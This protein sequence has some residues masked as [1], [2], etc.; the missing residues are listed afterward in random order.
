[1]TKLIKLGKLLTILVMAS[2]TSLT[3]MEHTAFLK[4]LHTP[5]FLGVYLAMAF[6]IGMTVYCWTLPNQP[7]KEIKNKAQNTFKIN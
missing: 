3:I 2:F 6:L 7:K 4:D 5:N 1:M